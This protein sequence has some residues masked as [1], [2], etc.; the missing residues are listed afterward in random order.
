[1]NFTNIRIDELVLTFNQY[2]KPLYHTC[3]MCGAPDLANFVLSRTNLDGHRLTSYVCDVCAEQWMED[4]T[5]IIEQLE[6]F[7]TEEFYVPSKWSLQD[8]LAEIYG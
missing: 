3:Q 7:D 5:P 1:M 2:D 4:C 8:A 6:L